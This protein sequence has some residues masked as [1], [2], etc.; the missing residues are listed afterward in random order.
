MIFNTKSTQKGFAPIVVIITL[1]ILGGLAGAFYLGTTIQKAPKQSP[2]PQS[3]SPT[4]KP[5]AAISSPTPLPVQPTSIPTTGPTANWKTYT[6]KILSFKY[7]ANLTLEERQKNFIVLLYDASNPQNVSVSIDARLTGNYENYDKAISS[8][9]AGLTNV[10]KEEM[11][12]GVKISGK[13][14]TG[15][16]EGQQI[17]I[18]LFK[19]GTGA[20]E[21]ETTTTNPNQIETFNQILSTF[22]F[23]Q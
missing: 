5:I 18:K 1:L 19:Y 13:V 9:K 8:A 10:Q 3:P 23:T 6:S 20:I 4:I 22:R 14:G 16:G 12:N 2:H 17:T 21:A 15:Y 11:V 7:P